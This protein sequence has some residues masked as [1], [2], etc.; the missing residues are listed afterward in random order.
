MKKRDEGVL[1][2]RFTSAGRRGAPVAPE[3]ELGRG[4]LGRV[5][6]PLVIT[7]FKHAENKDAKLALVQCPRC[8]KGTSGWQWIDLVEHPS[9]VLE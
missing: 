8:G 7:H 5:P 4:P 9:A 1:A 6:Y 3:I 2:C